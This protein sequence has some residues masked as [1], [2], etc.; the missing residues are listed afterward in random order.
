MN[1]FIDISNLVSNMESFV[2]VCYIISI[3]LFYE[4]GAKILDK[5]NSIGVFKC[6][7]GKG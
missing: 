6:T 4:L 3:L 2:S 7:L 1:S 5:K